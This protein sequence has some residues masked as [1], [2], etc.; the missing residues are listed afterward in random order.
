MNVC[1][2]LKAAGKME[3]MIG[4]AWITLAACS[5]TTNERRCLAPGL[6]AWFF[7]IFDNA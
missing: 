6:I 7:N 5:G 1:L 4:M 2:I 3:V